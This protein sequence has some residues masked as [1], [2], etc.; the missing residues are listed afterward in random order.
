MIKIYTDGSCLG[1][2][3]TG[4]WAYSLK[5]K[6]KNIA[7]Y[8]Y[9]KE[10]TNN[11]MELTAAIKALEFLKENEEEITV[12]TDSNYLKYGISSWITNW[13]KNNWKTANK[14]LVK[15]QDLW[16]TLD[17]LTISKKVNWDWVK[18]HSIDKFNNTVDELA[19]NAAEN[20][21]QSF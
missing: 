5:L 2:P 10:T 4:G 19:R 11:R 16:M 17:E 8:G 9:E 18:A 15:N 12:I 1:N 6:N 13:K 7:H 3:G 14:N 21:I 20:L